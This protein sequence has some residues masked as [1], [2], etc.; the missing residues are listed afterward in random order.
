[1]AQLRDAGFLVADGHASATASLADHDDVP[2]GVE[3]SAD[4]NGYGYFDPGAGPVLVDNARLAHYRTDMSAVIKSLLANCDM[5]SSHLPPPLIDDI[6]WELGD[7]R[8]SG[9]PKR[10]STWFARRL[11][12]PEVWDK[13]RSMMRSRPTSGLRI[14]LTSTLAPNLPVEIEQRH[15][16]VP[17]F[18]VLEHGAGLIVDA[19]ILAARI[20]N[21]FGR[22]GELIQHAAEFG[23][24]VIRGKRFVSRARSK[25]RAPAST[26][27]EMAFERRSGPPRRRCVR[28]DV[29]GLRGAQ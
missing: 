25:T 16:V 20:N 2:V 9:R 21:P 28:H 27:P 1:M 22:E 12:V 17:V 29:R 13:V 24:V 11:H 4:N 3:W 7:M 14:V 26:S 5:R 18:D 19:A 10:V 8:I 23:W 15:Q 6:F